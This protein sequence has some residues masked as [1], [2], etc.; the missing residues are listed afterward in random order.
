MFGAT[1]NNLMRELGA[2]ID[3]SFRVEFA[4]GSHF[5]TREAP[6]AFTL[7]FRNRSAN[8]S[9]KVGAKFSRSAP[10]GSCVT[11]SLSP[12]SVCRL[13]IWRRS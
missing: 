2:A 8:G 12:G 6:P 11:T 3:V 7:R 4:D 10:F 5:Q 13:T 9:T 1:V